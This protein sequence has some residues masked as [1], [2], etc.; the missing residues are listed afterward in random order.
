MSK[1]VCV[2]YYAMLTDLL[3][4]YHYLET[5]TM[6]W[7][8]SVFSYVSVCLFPKTNDL[9]GVCCVCEARGSHTCRGWTTSSMLGTGTVHTPQVASFCYLLCFDWW[10]YKGLRLHLLQN[11]NQCLPNIW[12]DI[13]SSFSSFVIFNV[14]CCLPSVTLHFH[15]IGHVSRF[16]FSTKTRN[17]IFPMDIF[18]VIFTLPFAS[19]IFDN[20]K[21]KCVC[22]S[23]NV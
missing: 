22:S 3:Q 17:S 13:W 11:E 5:Q 16:Y 12:V 8:S 1:G 19:C 10:H 20:T 7:S 14:W 9:D 15:L 23:Q 2:Y 4:R 21:E 18:V 6:S